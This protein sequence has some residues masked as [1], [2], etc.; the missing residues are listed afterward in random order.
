[1]PVYWNICFKCL[2]FLVWLHQGLQRQ[3][4]QWRFCLAHIDPEFTTKNLY[5]TA[6]HGGQQVQFQ[7]Q[8]SE[9]MQILRA[10]WLV[11]LSTWEFQ[12]ERWS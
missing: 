12:A 8:E 3:S 5:K 2:F 7:S 9:D 4:T 1:M 11:N 6:K 10:Y